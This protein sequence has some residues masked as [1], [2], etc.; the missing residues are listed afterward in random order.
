MER[1]VALTTDTPDALRQM[2]PLEDRDV[3]VSASLLLALESADA[4]RVAFRPAAMDDGGVV[5]AAVYVDVGAGPLAFPLEIIRTAALCLR[6]DPPFS[7]ADA[8]SDALT[9]AADMAQ[10]RAAVLFGGLN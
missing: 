2:M 1:P 10:A 8:L 7:G 3:L 4:R 6:L 9:E 5:V